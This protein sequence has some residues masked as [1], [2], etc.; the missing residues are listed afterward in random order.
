ME[1]T[2]FCPPGATYFETIDGRSLCTVR[3][4]GC[5]RDWVQVCFDDIRCTCVP[6][7][8]ARLCTV[9]IAYLDGYEGGARLV[10]MEA[11]C[12]IEGA[13]IALAA[14]LAKILTPP[15]P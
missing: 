7:G 13:V 14:I 9:S 15:L 10:P 3:P 12:E 8:Q 2:P 6:P 5:K 1:P 4:T 11:H